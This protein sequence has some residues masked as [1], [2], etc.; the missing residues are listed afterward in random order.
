[1]DSSSTISSYKIPTQMEEERQVEEINAAG[2]KLVISQE[3][4]PPRETQVHCSAVKAVA[5]SS[6][7][8]AKFLLG[9]VA[10]RATAVLRLTRSFLQR[11]DLVSVFGEIVGQFS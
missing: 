4:W 3:A 8:W 9:V 6:R 10:P 7:L 5:T 1:M 11:A 2:H